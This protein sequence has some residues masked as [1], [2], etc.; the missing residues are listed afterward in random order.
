LLYCKLCLV[1]YYRGIVHPLWKEGEP[2]HHSGPSYLRMELKAWAGL[3]VR[4]RR[5]CHFGRDLDQ[6]R[7]GMTAAQ[8]DAQYHNGIIANAP[9][10]DFTWIKLHRRYHAI[11]LHGATTAHP[12]LFRSKKILQL[13]VQGMVRMPRFAAL[14]LLLALAALSSGI[15]YAG[16][17]VLGIVAEFLGSGQSATGLL[18]GALFARLP[19]ISQGRLGTVGLLPRNARRPIMLVLLTWCIASLLYRGE[20]GSAVFPGFAAAFLLAYPWLRQKALDRI[21]SFLQ[22]SMRGPARRGASDP[23]IIDVKC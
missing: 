2:V 1:S 16:Y 22:G 18:F 11:D 23:K 14:V 15:S 13:I 9:A 12:H 7:E 10:L 5:P 17:L 8:C 21:R 4:R 3:L 6:R 19:W 20:T